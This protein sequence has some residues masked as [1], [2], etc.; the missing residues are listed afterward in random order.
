ML[1]AEVANLGPRIERVNLSMVNLNVTL[2]FHCPL[3]SIWLT[4]GMIRGLLWIS[5]WSFVK[6]QRSLML[7]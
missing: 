5:S 6:R 3:P 4:A 7:T 2:D 1:L